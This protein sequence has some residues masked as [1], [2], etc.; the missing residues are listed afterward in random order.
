MLVL[1]FKQKIEI[2]KKDSMPLGYATSQA[3]KAMMAILKEKEVSHSESTHLLHVCEVEPYSDCAC[4][5][6]RRPHSMEAN[7]KYLKTYN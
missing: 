3:R 5:E 2:N 6:H 7:Y 4:C 1:T